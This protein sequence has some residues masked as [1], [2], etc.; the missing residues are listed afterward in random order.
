MEESAR[1]VLFKFI[2]GFSHWGTLGVLDG[3]KPKSGNKLMLNSIQ[4]RLCA[5]AH[6]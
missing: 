2:L 4:E 6:T 3:I 5:I 1:T